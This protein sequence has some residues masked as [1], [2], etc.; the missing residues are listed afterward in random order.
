MRA[1]ATK[2]CIKLYYILRN[3]D[4]VHVIVLIKALD[5]RISTIRLGITCLALS[6]LRNSCFEL[7][8]NRELTVDG[9]HERH[10]EVFSV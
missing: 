9:L 1:K 6:E 7:F 4:H 2:W 5:V 3:L 10:I 8:P